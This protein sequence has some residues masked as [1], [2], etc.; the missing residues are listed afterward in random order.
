MILAVAVQSYVRVCYYTNWSQ[1]RNGK[2][3]YFLENN[4][5]KG[6]CT[7]LIFSFGK[8]IQSGNE[9][10]IEQYEWNDKDV[11]YKQVSDFWFIQIDHDWIFLYIKFLQFKL[12][13][14]F[15]QVL[16]DFENP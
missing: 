1:Y 3:K 16:V 5:Q 4:Y 14:S 9:Y 6:L 7:H 12:G 11:L 15:T 10:I 8:V 13:F 2:G